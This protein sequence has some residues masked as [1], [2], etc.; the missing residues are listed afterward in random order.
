[1]LKILLEPKK[2]SAVSVAADTLLAFVKLTAGV[3]TGSKALISDGLHSCADIFSSLIVLIGSI[4]SRRKNTCRL[5]PKKAEAASLFILSF[6]LGTT[7]VII[8]ISGLM[9]ILSVSEAAANIPSVSAL[10]VSVFALVIKETMFILTM[11]AAKDANDGI[12]L[13]NAR[14]H[15]SDVLSCLGSFFGILMSR[16]GFPKFDCIASIAIC[17]FVIKTAVDIFKRGIHC[18]LSSI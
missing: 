1:M 17:V 5:S 12:L 6:I 16:L 3:L 11:K 15:Q 4:L 14:H 7:G 2:I 8:G 10:C 13:A 18:A 9:S